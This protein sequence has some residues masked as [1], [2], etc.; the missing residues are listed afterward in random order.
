MKIN[1]EINKIIDKKEDKNM[2]NILKNRRYLRDKELAIYFG[3]GRS[4]VWYY[5]NKGMYGSIKVSP[6][7]TLFDVDEV[8]QALL[9]IKQ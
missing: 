5:R 6:R 4:T 3:I 8:E 1:K 2:K 9:L 7:V